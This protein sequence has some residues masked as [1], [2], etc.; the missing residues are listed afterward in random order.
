MGKQITLSEASTGNHFTVDEFN[1]LNVT[2]DTLGA[3]VYYIQDGRMGDKRLKIVNDSPALIAGVS[4]KLMAIT[5][6]GATQYVHIDRINF[7]SIVGNSTGVEFLYNMDGQTSRRI[8][9]TNSES[10]FMTT[11]WEK[12]GK[13]VYSFD[14]VNATSDTISLAAAHGDLTGTFIAGVYFETFGSS[15]EL[16]NANWKVTSSAY[17]GGKTVIT[18][19][20]QVPSGAS[21]TGKLVIRP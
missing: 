14:D 3:A 21:E 7:T 15:T 18:V 4:E 12:L 1:I 2:T 11:Y 19:T 16:M 6:N 20:E 10:V 13:T 17:S 5:V 8:Q 9:T